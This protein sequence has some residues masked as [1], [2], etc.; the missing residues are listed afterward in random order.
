[1]AA[2]I[3]KTRF[4][5]HL[6]RKVFHVLSGTLAVFLFLEVLGRKQSIVL[7][8]LMTAL[9]IG[10]DLL[11]I[12]WRPLNQWILKV[13]GPLMRDEEQAAPSAQLFYLLGM[14]WAFVMMPKVVAVQA[15]LTLAWMDP[16]A[17]IVG[18][19]FGK[20]TWNKV[21]T[22]FIPEERRIPAALGAKTVEGTFAGFL[23]ATFA[24]VVAWTGPWAKILQADGSWT[25][26][27]WHQ[28]LLFSL[29]GGLVAAVAE[30][31][32]SQWDDNAKIPFW[33]GTL[34]FILVLM[35]GTPVSF[36]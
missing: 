9:G 30:A 35:T 17:G 8:S 24:G 36:F 12:S 32:P 27:H 19:R 16:V 7:V 10:L 28:I 5:D 31:W 22:F 4:D 18:V 34:I 13:Y 29:V 23:S 15:V 1:L 2:K 14:W 3:S 11:R 6:S 21:F 25:S 20:K 33:T 26:P